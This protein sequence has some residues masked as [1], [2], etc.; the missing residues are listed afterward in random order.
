MDNGFF[1]RSGY[2][3]RDTTGKHIYRK[4]NGTAPYV[5]HA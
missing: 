1:R 2:P 5:R 3:A 4:A